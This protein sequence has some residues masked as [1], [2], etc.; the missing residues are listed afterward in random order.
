MERCL[1]D[2]S[3]NHVTDLMSCIAPNTI[4]RLATIAASPMDI[5]GYGPV[6]MQAVAKVQK[7]TA[8]LIRLLKSSIHE[9][10]AA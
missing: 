5:R 1:I 6:K 2:G 7:E 4:R 10:R 9:R 8:D 3:E